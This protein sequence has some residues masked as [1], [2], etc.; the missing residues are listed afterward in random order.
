VADPELQAPDPASGPRR[1]PS[2][3]GGA[4]YLLVLLGIGVGLAIVALGDWRFGVRWI[5]GALVVAAGC[6]LLVPAGQAGMLAVR[7]RLADTAVLAG[8]GALV[9]FLA[10]DIP[11]QP[12]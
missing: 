3:L 2:T 4:L 8:V 9:I 5:G 10:G 12:L 11:N 6:R 1:Y 7:H